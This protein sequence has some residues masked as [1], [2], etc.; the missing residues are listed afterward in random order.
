MSILKL[1]EIKSLQG[2]GNTVITFDTSDRAVFAQPPLTAVPAFSVILTSDQSIT[3]STA[4]VVQFNSVQYDTNNY[5]DAANYRY[6]PQIAGFYQFNGQVYGV[7]TSEDACYGAFYKNGADT[8]IRQ[9]VR[10]APGGTD[11]SLAIQNFSYIFYMNGS[12]DYMQTYIYV[13]GTST[14]VGAYY[15]Q[16]SGFLVRA[17]AA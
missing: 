2:T 6:T 4:T 15:T 5:W 1:E 17:G 12:T 16:F 10:L 3:P 7:A 8:L 11:L 13:N 9:D 14:S